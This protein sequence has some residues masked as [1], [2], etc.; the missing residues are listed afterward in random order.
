MKTEVSKK[1]KSKVHIK[2]KFQKVETIKEY[3]LEE[4]DR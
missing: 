1:T 3:V 2:E 4:E